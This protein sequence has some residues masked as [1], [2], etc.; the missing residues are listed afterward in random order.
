[1]RIRIILDIFNGVLS[2]TWHFLKLSLFISWPAL[3]AW[4]RILLLE[5][6]VRVWS[7][8]IEIFFQSAMRASRWQEVSPIY[9]EEH[10]PQLNLS[11]IQLCRPQGTRSLKWKKIE[12]RG[13]FRKQIETEFGE[14]GELI[15][16]LL[17][18]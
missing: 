15:I 14:R 1:M 17:N 2:V 6:V 7:A 5:G 4:S 13:Y 9:V 3:R 18:A 16:L 10:C 12:S 11:T 8:M